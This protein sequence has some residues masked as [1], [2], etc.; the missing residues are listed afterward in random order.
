MQKISACVITYNDEHTVAWSVGSVQWADEIVVVDTGSTDRKS[1]FRYTP[2]LSHENHELES[3]SPPGW[4]TNVLA[5][6]NA[7]GWGAPPEEPGRE[8]PSLA[9]AGKNAS[10]E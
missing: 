10:V 8:A 1:R 4:T 2:S 3:R 9:S 5:H 7:Q 6:E